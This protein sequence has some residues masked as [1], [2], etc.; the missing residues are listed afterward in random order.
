[1][2]KTLLSFIFLF[3]LI[4]VPSLGADSSSGCGLGWAIMKDNSLISS[5]SR[6]ITNGTFLNS[7]FGMTS[8][9]LGCA[10]HSIVKNESKAIHYAE[11]NHQELM[12]NIAQ[13]GG[14]VLEGFAHV[15]QYQG[16]VKILGEVVQRNFAT[17]YPHQNTSPQQVIMNMQKVF[18]DPHALAGY[19]VI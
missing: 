6:A 5:F 11:A 16:D 7:W 8:G 19:H 3:L 2:K 18:S 4:S 12:I 17:I 13:G 15:V 14:E 10:R 9:T 1:V